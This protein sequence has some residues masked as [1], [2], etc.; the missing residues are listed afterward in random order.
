MSVGCD[1]EEIA[2]FSRLLRS[3]RFMAETFTAAERAHI[4]ASVRPARSAAGI[5]CAK[6]ACA[7]A[8]GRG[9]YGLLP[10]ELSVT[11]DGRGAPRLTLCGA[12]AK[13]F[14]GVRLCLSVSHSG[15]YAMAV[16]QAEPF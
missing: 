9:L 1:L 2:R 16:V 8:L 6:E 11:W 3:A 14:P 13:A 7:K 4:A 15:G 12:A 5:W 10:Q